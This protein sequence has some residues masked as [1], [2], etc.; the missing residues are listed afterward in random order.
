MVG[1]GAIRKEGFCQITT[2]SVEICE[3]GTSVQ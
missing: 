2:N 3:V 1:G